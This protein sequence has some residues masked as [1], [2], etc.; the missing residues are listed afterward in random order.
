MDRGSRRDRPFP[1]DVRSVIVPSSSS[2]SSLPGM[3]VSAKYIAHGKTNES[4]TDELP[5]ECVAHFDSSDS[6][7]H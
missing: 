7:A 1:L 2:S 4:Y 5:C 6:I 3:T